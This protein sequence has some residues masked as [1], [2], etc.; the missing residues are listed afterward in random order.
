MKQEAD[1]D[2]RVWALE[3]IETSRIEFSARNEMWAALQADR[4]ARRIG[5]PTPIWAVEAV[6]RNRQ[7]AREQIERSRERFFETGNPMHACQAYLEARGIR[8]PLPEWVLHYIDHSM[9]VYYRAFQSFATVPGQENRPAEVFAEA[10]GM[11]APKVG[12]WHG[13]TG[14]GTVWTRFGDKDWITRAWM[15]QSVIE[16]W[17]RA[18]KPII[19]PVE[20]AAA[21]YN[22]RYPSKKV[23]TR[24]MRRAWARY[25]REYTTELSRSSDVANGR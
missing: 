23:S 18:G 17:S 1:P 4:L 24:T 6:E 5:E 19:K 9:S 25:Q 15:V 13:R 8:D 3:G 10:F 20:E 12:G 22:K 14:S 2:F 11:K 21:R 16:G 7:L